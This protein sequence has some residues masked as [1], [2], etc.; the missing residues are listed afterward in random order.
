[1]SHENSPLQLSVSLFLVIET[2]SVAGNWTFLSPSSVDQ[3]LKFIK[4][5]KTSTHDKFIAMTGYHVG[6]VNIL[7]RKYAIVHLLHTGLSW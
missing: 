3:M 2:L 7:P 4:H 6:N 5:N 1:M